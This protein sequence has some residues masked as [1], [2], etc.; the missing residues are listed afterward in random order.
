M[1]SPSKKDQKGKCTHGADGK[2]IHCLPVKEQP[3]YLPFD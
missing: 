3:T 2:C 1:E